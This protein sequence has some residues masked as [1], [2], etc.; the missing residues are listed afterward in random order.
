MSPLC[1]GDSAVCFANTLQVSS[2]FVLYIIFIAFVGR[3]FVLLRPLGGQEGWAS[4]Q[5]VTLCSCVSSTYTPFFRKVHGT[6]PVS[7]LNH[8]PPY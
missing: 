4:S 7:A 1:D 6:F 8:P 3:S 5:G 2:F